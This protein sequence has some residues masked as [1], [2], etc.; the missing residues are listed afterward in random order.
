MNKRLQEIHEEACVHISAAFTKLSGRKT[1][2]NIANPKIT[3]V[4][5]LS[6]F[7]D[8]DEIVAGVYLPVTG[9]TKG[10]ALLILPKETAFNLCDFLLKREIGTTQELTGMD[11]SALK[12]AGNIFCGTYFTTLANELKIK[13]IEHL[14]EFSF[15]RF[16]GILTELIT[17]CAAGAEKTL[18]VEIE[19]MFTELVL[20]G[21]FVLLLEKKQIEH[22]IGSLEKKEPLV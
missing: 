21:Y 15:E 6:P 10:A 18:V 7:I 14:P 12:E 8:A 20:Q 5:E 13:I 9:E 4:K 16:G 2:V 22:I 11:E 3:E 19:F 17:K 1:I